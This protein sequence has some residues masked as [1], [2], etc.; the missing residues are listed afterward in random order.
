MKITPLDDG[1]GG[2][3]PPTAMT[4]REIGDYLARLVWESFS[5]FITDGDAE[6]LLGRLGLTS[7]QGV[8]A[9]A[10]AEEILIFLMWA[11]TRGLQLAFVG[12]EPDEQVVE[13]LDAFHAAIFEDMIIHGTPRNELPIFEQRVSARYSE[14]HQAAEQSDAQLGAAAVRAIADDD[15]FSEPMAIALAERAI[16][17]ADPLKDYLEDVKLA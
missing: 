16:A 13:A 2:F 12:K 6:A 4:P 14:Y 11:H 10:Q 3:Q 5:D 1:A 7:V 17:V 9:D 8:P 15:P